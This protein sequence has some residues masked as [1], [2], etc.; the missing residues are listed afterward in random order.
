[1]ELISAKPVLD[2]LVFQIIYGGGYTY[3]D[4]CGQTLV[5]IE[6]ARPDWIPGDVSTHSGQLSNEVMRLAASFSVDRFELSA[7]HIMTT[8][9]AG[10]GAVAEEAQALWDTIRDNL[11]LTEI[12]RVAVRFNWLLAK[13]SIEVAE[14]ALVGAPMK[15]VLPEPWSAA[16]FSPTTRSM[17]A[18]VK[19]DSVEYRVALQTATRREGLQPTSLV[20]TDPRFL[21][22]GRKKAR[23]D[24][25]KNRLNYNANPLYGV[26]LDVDCVTFQPPHVKAASYITGQAN[27][28]REHFVPMLDNL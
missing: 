25:I 12:V 1:M 24:A 16:G 13:T 2:S 4:R 10:L 18:V 9:G 8:K 15:L 11:A 20:A 3:L 5:D 28:C 21:P 27:V 23:E 22:A 6:R 19:K 26:H 14:K 17:V 7:T